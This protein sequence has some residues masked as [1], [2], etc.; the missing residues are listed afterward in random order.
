[1]AAKRGRKPRIPAIDACLFT[2]LTD[3]ELAA[4]KHELEDLY[5]DAFPLFLKGVAM[6][7]EQLVEHLKRRERLFHVPAKTFEKLKQLVDNLLQPPWTQDQ[8]KRYRWD[9]VRG[10]LDSS[11][12]DISYEEACA[13]A[14][15]ACQDTPAAAGPRMMGHDYR[16]VEKALPVG[17][18]HARTYRK[19]PCL[20]PAERECRDARGP[21]EQLEALRMSI[22]EVSGDNPERFEKLLVGYLKTVGH[23]KVETLCDCIGSHFPAAVEAIKLRRGHLR[24]EAKKSEN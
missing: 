18:R 4:L 21:E 24:R 20:T 8:I 6:T 22:Q 1:M 7:R 17:K 2:G 23:L 19:R 11:E 9:L 3:T 12:W 5:A 15:L 14:S 10:L 16:A 13:M